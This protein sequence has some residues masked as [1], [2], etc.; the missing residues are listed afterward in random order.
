MHRFFGGVIGYPEASSRSVISAQRAGSETGLFSLSI[1]DLY[2]RAGAG[3][4]T[5]PATHAELHG[6]QHR[7]LAVLFLLQDFVSAGKGGCTDS[8]FGIAD[9]GITFFEVYICVFVH[10]CIPESVL[11]NLLYRNIYMHNIVEKREVS[12]K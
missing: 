7:G 3:G 11:Q 12:K 4:N 10:P 1:F 6:E 2:G 8:L 9:P 5:K